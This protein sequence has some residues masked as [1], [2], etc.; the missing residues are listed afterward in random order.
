MSKLLCNVLKIS[1]GGAFA[2]PPRLRAWCAYYTKCK[3]S[4]IHNA[5]LISAC[6]TDIENLLSDRTADNSTDEDDCVP[7]KRRRCNQDFDSDTLIVL[8]RYH[9]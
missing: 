5:A 8:S 7:L 9:L 3:N 6:V 4:Q 1:G 2:S